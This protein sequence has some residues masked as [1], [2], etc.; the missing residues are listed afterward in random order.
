MKKIFLVLV[1]CFFVKGAFAQENGFSIGLNL[2]KNKNDEFVGL[3][4][5]SP[6]LAE[7]CAVRLSFNEH[8]FDYVPFGEEKIKQAD[9]W[10]F[11]YG[12]TVRTPEI[13]DVLFPYLDIGGIGMKPHENFSDKN[14][15]G[16]L[17]MNFGLELIQTIG[18]SQGIGYFAEAGFIVLINDPRGRRGRTTLGNEYD[19]LQFAL[20][21][22]LYFGK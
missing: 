11:S 10:S 2:G 19:Y 7:F 17:Y 13:A 1:L 21:L 14:F 20:G 18:I 8:V 15:Q 16:G 22:R 3:N 6:Y 5:T 4:L 12:I 9:Y